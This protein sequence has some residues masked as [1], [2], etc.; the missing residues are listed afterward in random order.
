MTSVLSDEVLTL[1]GEMRSLLEEILAA[2]TNIT[3][4]SFRVVYLSADQIDRI[5]RALAAGE[6]FSLSSPPPPA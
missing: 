1:L 3:A 2:D 6:P 4:A 5:R